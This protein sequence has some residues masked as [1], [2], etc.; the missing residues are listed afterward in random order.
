ML[1]T[2]P[3]RLFLLKKILHHLQGRLHTA[4]GQAISSVALL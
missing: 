3:L 1:L 4:H 2:A